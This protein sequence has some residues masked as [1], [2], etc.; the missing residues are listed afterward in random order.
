[1][2]LG[3]HG[4]AMVPLPRHATVDGKPLTELVDEG[5]LEELCTSGRATGEPRSSPC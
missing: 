5:T 3:S 4:E 2:T 1:M